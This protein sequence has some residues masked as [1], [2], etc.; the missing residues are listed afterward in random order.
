[1]AVAALV[2]LIEL[3]GRCPLA[4][5][6]RAAGPSCRVGIRWPL[7]CA[8]RVRW[9]MGGPVPAM[10]R[11]WVSVY[12]ARIASSALLRDRRMTFEGRPLPPLLGLFCSS[13]IRWTWGLPGRS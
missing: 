7:P 4:S 3:V 9:S 6:A 2:Y 5:M 11:L 13:A 1:M 10:M 8:S 12:S